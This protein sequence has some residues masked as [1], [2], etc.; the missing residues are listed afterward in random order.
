MLFRICKVY[1]RTFYPQDDD[2]SKLNYNQ[3]RLFP[4]DLNELFPEE[5]KTF[6]EK[7][8][9]LLLIVKVAKKY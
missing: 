2:Q 6:R 8:I 9:A 3:I 1:E 7:I 5:M 4:E